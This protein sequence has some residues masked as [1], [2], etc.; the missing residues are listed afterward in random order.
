MI[1]FE[2]GFPELRFPGRIDFG[3]I[4]ATLAEYDDGEL[5]LEGMSKFIRLTEVSGDAS[6]GLAWFTPDKFLWDVWRRH[7]FAAL[8]G[9]VRQLAK[10]ELLYIGMSQDSAYKRLVAK[11]HEARLKILT[12]ELARS[13]S[14]RVSDEV[15]FFFFDIEPLFVSTY[16][17]DDE[18]DDVAVEM[19]LNP[20]KKIAPATV[21][22]DAE[23]AFIKI[24]RTPYN[25]KRYM[26]YPKI[27]NGL[28]DG[29]LERY[30]YSI[31]E[32]VV[33]TVG[34]TEIT[35]G[36][37]EGLPC[38]EDADFIFIDGTTATFVDVSALQ[39]TEFDGERPA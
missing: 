21:I 34:D 28:N 39:L 25:K 9:D 3:H 30:G 35:G 29:V 2:I 8:D 32:D 36:Y 15:M 37:A 11:P 26:K 23:K 1:S 14:G 18:I 27:A 6:R 33:F 38:A 12:N 22:E 10:Y 17:E 13:A 5:K 7:K 4:A 31:A 19:M 16:G 24:L 20:A